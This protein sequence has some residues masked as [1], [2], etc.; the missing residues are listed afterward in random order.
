MGSIRSELFGQCKFVQI[1]T[2]NEARVKTIL[3]DKHVS[4]RTVDNFC[5][6][7]YHLLDTPSL[8]SYKKMGIAF[9]YFPDSLNQSVVTVRFTE[10]G[11]MIEES[12]PMS[13]FIINP[14]ELTED[15][16][17]AVAKANQLVK[18]MDRGWENQVEN[19]NLYSV[20]KLM[21]D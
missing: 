21:E 5:Y 17:E 8:D 11:T 6:I 7:A 2:G 20:S 12:I 1:P 13:S 19:G 15:I 4:T 3:V 9:N 18:E 16:S 10:T 14:F